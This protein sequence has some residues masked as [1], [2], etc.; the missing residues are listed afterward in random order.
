MPTPSRF[1]KN[2]HIPAA[3][4]LI[5]GL[6]VLVVIGTLLLS[7][8]V[9]SYGEPL[10]LQQSLFTAVSALA[11]TGLSTIVPS[12]DLSPTGKVFLMLLIQLGGIGYMVLAILVFRLLGRTISLTERMA[13]Q[14]ALGLIHLQGIVQLSIRVFFTV[15]ILE[16]IGA[17]CLFVHWSNVGAIADKNFGYVAFYAMFH[18]VSSFCNAGFDLFNGRYAFPLDGGSMTIMGILIVIGGLGIPVLFD[19]LTY[20]SRRKLS[21][22][23]KLTMIAFVVLF[24]VG[25]AAIWLSESVPGGKLDGLPLAR[26]IGLSL[27]QSVS[28]RTAGFSALGG[29][30]GT[31]PATQLVMTSLMFIGCAPASMGGGITTGTFIVM[32]L[33]MIAYIRRNSTPIVYGR[34]IPGEMVRKAAAVMTISIFVVTASSWLIM[35]SHPEWSMGESVFEIVSAFATCGLTLERTSDLNDFGQGVVMFM[36]FW[37]RLGALTILFAFTRSKSSRRISYPEEK[38]LLG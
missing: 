1:W 23:T 8:P 12:I 37:G 29:L 2:I 7:L 19:F 32:V 14:D 26:Q 3:V 22:H 24:L 18:S 21:L 36:M 27:F 28:C 15:I 30:D 13:L 9:S 34:A 33:A 31:N 5:F 10:T 16:L 35:L 17:I 11:V 38:I 4:R 20:H 25:G 6:L